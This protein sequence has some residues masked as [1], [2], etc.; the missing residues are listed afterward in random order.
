M[1]RHK[2][3]P[4]KLLMP[5]RRACP[6]ATQNIQ[7]DDGMA[8][9]VACLPPHHP[10]ETA[11]LEHF[12]LFHAKR[13]S[14]P[15]ADYMLGRPATVMTDARDPLN[16]ILY[17]V[18]D[19][20]GGVTQAHLFGKAGGEALR[21]GIRRWRKWTRSWQRCGPSSRRRATCMACA[22]LFSWMW[23]ERVRR[24]LP[25]TTPPAGSTSRASPS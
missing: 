17:T 16:L 13:G 14:E 24:L 19:F 1:P 25:S 2:W 11:L 23:C 7:G 10:Q 20:D 6:P 21:S 9:I 18:L 15:F 5:V 22:C 4:H 3:P 8:V 12:Q